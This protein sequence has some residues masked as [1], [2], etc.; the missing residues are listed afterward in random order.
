MKSKDQLTKQVNE[1]TEKITDS[2]DDKKMALQASM[3]NEDRAWQDAKCGDI[4]LIKENE[5]IPADIIVLMSSADNG[6]AFFQT[7]T[8][9]EEK[10]FK[11]K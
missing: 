1:V 5:H 6:E 9:D 7:A 2:Q 4:M 3:F 10:A 11:H 8:L